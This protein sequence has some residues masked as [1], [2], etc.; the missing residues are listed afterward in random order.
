MLV[1]QRQRPGCT[2]EDCGSLVQQVDW[3]PIVISLCVGGL[4][5]S[6]TAM[7]LA[8]DW[9]ANFKDNDNR[10]SLARCS[11]IR[12]ELQSLD[13]TETY[14][15]AWHIKLHYTNHEVHTT[16]HIAVVVDFKV[17]YGSSDHRVWRDGTIDCCLPSIGPIPIPPNTGK[18]WPIPNNPIPVLFEPKL[19][20][21]I[22]SFAKPLIKPFPCRFHTEFVYSR[23]HIT[24]LL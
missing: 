6:W 24:R 13:F 21:V 3:L 4:L 15:P 11:E 8:R 14:W 20:F 1:K 18:Y 22:W 10:I 7:Y 23:W 12:A 19:V 2:I 17:S 9:T 16:S 5:S